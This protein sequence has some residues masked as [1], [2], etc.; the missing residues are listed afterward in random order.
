[1]RSRGDCSKR[2]GTRVGN[3]GDERDVE[4]SGDGGTLGGTTHSWLEGKKAFPRG[5][6][7]LDRGKKNKIIRRRKRAR[8]LLT[9]LF[10]GIRSRFSGSKVAY[11]G[12]E[13]GGV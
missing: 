12:V 13:A 5:G 10:E 1:M 4:T 7:H 8:L 6:L 11:P 2:K 3:P 9:G